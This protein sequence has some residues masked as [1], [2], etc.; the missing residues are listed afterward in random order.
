MNLFIFL[1]IVVLLLVAFFSFVWWLLPVIIIC[2]LI[3][4]FLKI[5]GVIKVSKGHNYF[6]RN[7]DFDSEP[8]DFYRGRKGNSEDIIDVEYTQKDDL[9]EE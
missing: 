9:E 8:Q 6:N 5:I 3:W 7:D 4:S 1:L 2:Y